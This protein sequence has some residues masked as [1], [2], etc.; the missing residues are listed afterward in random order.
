MNKINYLCNLISMNKWKLTYCMMWSVGLFFATFYSVFGQADFFLFADKKSLEVAQ[1][2]IMPLVMA[3]DLYLWDVL[4]NVTLKG[5]LDYS[6]AKW[7]FV[8]V[9]AFLTFFAF[10]LIGNN[11]WAGWI[12]FILSWLSLTMIKVATTDSLEVKVYKIGED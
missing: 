10:S 4:Y 1:C 7:V 9:I 6:T 5:R 12:F 3:M 11:V 8:G 2:Y